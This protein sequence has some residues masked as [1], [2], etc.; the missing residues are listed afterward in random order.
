[1][2]K[3]LIAITPRGVLKQVV[4][5]NGSVTAQLKWNPGFGPQATATFESVQAFVDSEVLRRCDKY[6]PFDSG[7]LKKSGILF[8]VIG[9]GLVIYNTPYA[10][11]WYFK[12]AKF[13]GAP[14]RGNYWFERM[15][16]EGG[17]AAILAGAKKLAGGI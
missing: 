5:K 11:R 17:K 1:M 14:T 2:R 3:L 7:F 16:N 15:K 8:T 9:S 10:R 13:Q 4:T 12:P 6:V